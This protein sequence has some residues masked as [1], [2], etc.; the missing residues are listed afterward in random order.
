MSPTTTT[1]RRV[2]RRK[3]RIAAAHHG[4]VGTLRSIMLCSKHARRQAHGRRWA[5]HT[6][7]YPWF[8]THTLTAPIGIA[9]ELWV[10]SACHGQA[11][12]QDAADLVVVIRVPCA[13]ASLDPLSLL[14]P[15]STVL[16]SSEE[17]SIETSESESTMSSIPRRALS[18]E[19]SLS[20]LL[21]RFEE[22]NNR[23]AEFSTEDERLR[24]P[25]EKKAVRPSK[26]QRRSAHRLREAMG[27]GSGFEGRHAF[28]KA[29]K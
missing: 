22:L 28:R 2:R 19:D 29:R 16:N 13:M 5:D 21:V 12:V 14:P 20:S 25:D 18:D 3:H 11:R 8:S 23:L 27:D 17:P 7:V 10:L 6:Y 26:R 9:Q 4:C 24:C 15:L 1:T